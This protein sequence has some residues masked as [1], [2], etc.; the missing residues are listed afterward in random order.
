MSAKGTAASF[1]LTLYW[2]SH[3]YTCLA[4]DMY[5]SGGW[6]TSPT[7]NSWELGWFS[8]E[9]RKLWGD[10]TAALWYLKGAFKKDRERLSTRG[11][12]DRT[13][14]K[15]FKL[16]EGRSRLDIRKKFFMMRVA[17]DRNCL[18]R[19]ACTIPGRVSSQ[20]G[21]DFEQ[22]SLAKDVPAHGRRGLNYVTFK[23]LF[24]PKQFHNSM[25][26]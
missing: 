2:S 8:L 22:P 15:G 7:K 24:Q 5:R 3:L 12:S 26:L 19:K 21:W 6:N 16:K 23:D 17:R 9:N 1:I 18:P 20:A 11:S 14:C 25:V 10:F 13:K 4:I